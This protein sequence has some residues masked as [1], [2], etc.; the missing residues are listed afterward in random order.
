VGPRTPAVKWL[1]VPIALSVY[2]RG[3]IV[4]VANDM[5]DADVV[6]AEFERGNESEL[7]RHDPER[8]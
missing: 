3:R 8:C 6:F 2:N 7:D 5:V 1:R 4:G